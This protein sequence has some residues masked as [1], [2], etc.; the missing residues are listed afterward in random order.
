MVT[1]VFKPAVGLGDR[2]Q[3][4]LEIRPTDIGER[5]GE[6]QGGE[7][8]RIG[9]GRGE[10][11]N[12]GSI[13]AIDAGFANM[14]VVE[15]RR[16]ALVDAVGRRSGLGEGPGRKGASAAGTVADLGRR[17]RSGGLDGGEPPGLGRPEIHW[18]DLSEN[19]HVLNKNLNSIPCESGKIT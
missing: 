15:D 10:P 12:P 19:G 3:I 9:C 17:R 6:I 11:A 18:R 16:Q 8:R 4:W 14:G 7:F 2:C 1:N 5:L 13:G